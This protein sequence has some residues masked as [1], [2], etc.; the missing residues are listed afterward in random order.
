[1]GF[2]YRILLSFKINYH[3]S[4]TLLIQTFYM[5]QGK[6]YQYVPRIHNNSKIFNSFLIVLFFFHNHKYQV[7]VHVGQARSIFIILISI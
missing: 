6:V 3:S 1:M 7:Q 5:L 2:F 4:I